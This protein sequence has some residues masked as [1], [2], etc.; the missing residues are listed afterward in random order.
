VWLRRCRN[1]NGASMQVTIITERHIAT[2][3]FKDFR[4]ELTNKGKLT[5]NGYTIIPL[6]IKMN[7]DN[8]RV[9]TSWRAE[10]EEQTRKEFW[11]FSNTIADAVRAGNNF[12]YQFP[13]TNQDSTH[14]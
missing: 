13:I 4:A 2:C 12:I 3:D 11:F 8:G 14:D 9:E 7:M 5:E 10:S 1:F 6:E